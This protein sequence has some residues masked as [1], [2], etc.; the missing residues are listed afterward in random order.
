[1]LP[2]KLMSGMNFKQAVVSKINEILDYLKTQRIVGDGK[3]IVVNQY[4]SAVGIQ[5][6]D[7]SSNNIIQAGEVSDSFINFPVTLTR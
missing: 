2:Q 3:N 6:K 5:L 1:M 4:T 7:T